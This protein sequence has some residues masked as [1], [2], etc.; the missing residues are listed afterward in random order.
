MSEN[1]I[2]SIGYMA[3]RVCYIGI[4]KEEAISR[5]KA[6]TGSENVPPAKVIP[7]VDG[8]FG[9]YSIWEIDPD[10]LKDMAGE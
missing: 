1:T 3:N 2:V 9:A 4:S 8:K 5:W 7:V 6:E 10:D